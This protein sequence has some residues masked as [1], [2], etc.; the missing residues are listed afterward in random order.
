MGSKR[1]VVAI[2]GNSLI[3]DPQHQR[4]E[5][6]YECLVETCASIAGLIEAGH[7]VIITHGNGPQVG[8]ILRRSELAKHELHEVPLPSCIADTQGAIGYLIQRAMPSVLAGGAATARVATVVTQVVVDRDD[9][10][11]GTPS[12]PIGGFMDAE[13]AKQRVAEDGWTVAVD[14]S[15]GYRRV[16]ASPRPIDIVELAAIRSLVDSGFVVVAVGGGGVPVVRTPEGD[17]TG[18]DAVIDKD[19]ASS[20]LAREL[21]ADI[22]LISTGVE[23]VATGYGTPHEKPIDVLTIDDARR[24]AAE[25]EFGPG[26]MLP[27]VEASVEFVEAT[28]RQVIITDPSNLVRAL[29][30]CAGTRIVP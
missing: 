17:L 1:L 25:G 10:G 27:K 19:F 30:G 14:G 6:Q 15:A 29:A 28:G 24:L 8:F 11:F 20:L 9:P 16:V 21:G 7:R 23:K 5:D 12:K 18:V 4:V 13:T 2:G 22:L 3:R 26:S